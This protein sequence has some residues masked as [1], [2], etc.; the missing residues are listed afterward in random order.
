MAAQPAEAAGCSITSLSGVNSLSCAYSILSTGSLAGQLTVGVTGGGTLNVLNGATYSITTY[1]RSI[2]IIGTITVPAELIVGGT[3][4]GTVNVSGTGSTLNVGGDASLASLATGTMNLTSGGRLVVG[5]DLTVGR[6]IGVSGG[7]SAGTDTTIAVTRNLEIAA[8]AYGTGT[9]SVTSGRADALTVGGRLDVGVYGTGSLSLG[10]GSHA[11]VTGD[12]VLGVS[13]VSVQIPGLSSFGVSTGTGTID[14][15]GASALSVGGNL[16]VGDRGT[17]TLDVSEDSTVAVTG[18]LILGRLAQDY[19]LA[20]VLA[21]SGS[22][23]G[24][25]TISGDDS[26]VTATNVIVG[27][28]GTGVVTVSAGGSLAASGAIVLGNGAYDSAVTGGPVLGSGTV[29]VTGTGSELSGTSL[30]IGKAGTGTLTVSDGGHVAI[31]ATGSGAIIL[32]ETAASTGTVTIGDTGSQLSGTSLTVGKAGTGTLTVTDGGDVK[33]GATGA[34][35]IT[36][37][38]AAGSTGTVNV[39]AAAASAAAAA[40]TLSAGTLAFGAGDGTLVLNHLAP[41]SGAYTLAQTITGAGAIDVLSGATTL[42]GDASGF[43]GTTSVRKGDALSTVPSLLTVTGTLGGTIDVSGGG[44]LAGTGTVGSVEVTDG[45]L[46]GGLYQGWDVGSYASTYVPGTLAVTGTLGLGADSTYAVVATSDARSSSVAAT[47]AV[48]LSGGSVDVMAVTGTR[49][50]SVLTRYT[51]LTSDT[52]V[53]GSFDSSVSVAGVDYLS[54][55]LRYLDTDSDTYLDTVQLLLKRTDVGIVDFA[56]T[57]NQRAVG[58]TLDALGTGELYEA[59][60]TL[61]AEETPGA[62]TGLIGEGQATSRSLM[63]SDS[64]FQRDVVIDRLRQA[65]GATG[66]SVGGPLAYDAG[67][68]L[69]AN[70][71]TPFTVWSQAVGS[72]GRVGDPDDNAGTLRRAQRGVTVGADAFVSPFGDQ[73]W[74]VGLAGGY[75]H[76]NATIDGRATA[77]QLDSY[78][79]TLYAGTEWGPVA[80]RTGLSGAWYDIDSDRTVAF[81]GFSD[82]LTASYD[83]RSLQTFAEVALAVGRGPIRAEPYA[84]LAYVHTRTDGFSETGG[85]AALST[86]AA[87]DDTGFTTLGLRA[88][89]A[90]DTFGPRTLELSGGVAWR[91]AFGDTS[92]TATSAFVSGSDSFVV[93]GT[94]IAEDSLLVNAG[95]SAQLA[96]NASVGLRY[97]GN[98]ARDTRDNGGKVDLSLKF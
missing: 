82:H 63:I 51:V 49:A 52:A 42:S 91:H 61:T 16:I 1:S 71:A 66:A 5:R 74:R 77:L 23:S 10:N 87:S 76:S 45:T 34:G 35:V 14:L 98:F 44:I 85:L 39:G 37:A 48:T 64:Q 22:G 90:F 40:G 78:T 18:D 55:S 72:W 92:P 13:K 47:G 95:I 28:Q 26:A 54:G 46:F 32:G 68:K 2:P 97:L 3:S 59:V 24:T 15:T 75:G 25:V 84:G 58:R 69:P 30:T 41:I 7:L 57:D 67:S 65:F 31:G 11:N 89:A 21:F 56:T 29:T 27:D 38:E 80:L 36:I 33:V 81:P 79:G 19:A 62:L 60:A 43:T 94:P 83:A 53:N 4:S 93:A 8:G 6:G 86:A 17:G 50:W 20:N 96:P 70:A 73:V 9:M 12:T 88:A